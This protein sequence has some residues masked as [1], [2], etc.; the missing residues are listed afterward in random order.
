LEKP[1][2]VKKHKQNRLSQLG[3]EEKSRKSDK[4]V[5]LDATT[6][7]MKNVKNA[8]KNLVFSFWFCY[9]IRPALST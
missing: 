1:K 5:Q 9:A 3:T 2:E 7:R 6:Q 4:C 8:F